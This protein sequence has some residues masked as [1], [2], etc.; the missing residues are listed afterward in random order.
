MKLLAQNTKQ[1]L[2]GGYYTP[3]ELTDFIVKWAF[4]DGRKKTVLE[5]S[6]G[7]GAFLE[8]LTKLNA[9]DIISCTGVELDSV[10][11][12]KSRGVVKNFPS[13]QVIND[14]F[15]SVF[16]TDLIYKEYDVIVG[17]PP[18]IRYQYLTASQREIQ[19]QILVN[20]LMKSNKLINSWVSFVVASVQLLKVG[21]KIGLVIPAELLQVAYAED[22]RLFLVNSLSKI[23]VITFTELVFPDVQQEVIVL[24][25]EKSEETSVDSRISL[26][27][28]SNLQSLE[29]LDLNSPIDYKEVDH[30][31]EKWTQYFL[32]NEEINLVR[33]VR[34]DKHFKRFDEI[35]Q[36]DI[37][38]TTGNNKYFSVSKAVVERYEL[39]PITLPLIGRSAHASGIFFDY[40]NW[41]EN[42]NKGLLAQ[43]VYFPDVPL[44]Q[45]P[46]L[47]QEYIKWGEENGHSKGYKLGLR[48]NWYHIPSVWKPDAFFLRRNDIFPKFVLNKVGAVSTDT[49]HRIRFNNGVDAN[50]VLL[51]YYNSI[52]LAFTE[53]EGRSYGGG[54]L[55]VLP[56]E[57]EK[58]MLPDVQHLDDKLTIELLEKID[59]TIKNN[60]AVDSLLDEIDKLVLVEFLGIE[61]SVVRQFRGM[62]KKLMTRRRQRK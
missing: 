47:Q 23:S 30:N 49:M 12:E 22:L 9:D 15:F 26:I 18:Y 16:R 60:I 35:A 27:E 25:G 57:V 46:P 5:P 59:Y 10:E 42:V 61:E 38:I 31:S 40:D 32:S 55:E 50:K 13:F 29:H 36:V 17:N 43:L 3:R 1:K 45:L 53:I 20:N 62:W 39:S 48:K 7:D 8:S 52:T 51:S 21:G 6:C 33:K 11:A 2:R 41:Q 4:H 44:E 34:A 58:I 14:D 54:V 56:G 37:G 24:L 28:L 19:S